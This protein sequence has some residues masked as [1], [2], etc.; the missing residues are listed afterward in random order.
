MGDFYSSCFWV[1]TLILI[2]SFIGLNFMLQMQG[3]YLA[4]TD[5]RMILFY[6]TSFILIYYLIMMIKSKKK[7]KTIK[8]NPNTLEKN[9]LT[10]LDDLEKKYSS[11]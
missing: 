9:E 10:S 11:T 7:Q 3:E 6:G 2:G 5:S 1:L 4:L 8:K